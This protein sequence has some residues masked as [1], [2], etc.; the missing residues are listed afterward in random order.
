M[1]DVS[2]LPKWAQS[3]IET[4]EMRVQESERKHREA[5]A[6]IDLQP[7]DRMVMI[8]PSKKTIYFDADTDGISVKHDKGVLEI[9]SGWGGGLGIRPVV[10]NVINVVT[11]PR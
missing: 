8:A 6:L 2:K 1:G 5:L 11:E 9:R 10:S 3:H 4:L 7:D